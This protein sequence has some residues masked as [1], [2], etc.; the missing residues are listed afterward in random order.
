MFSILQIKNIEKCHLRV[1]T[2]S[3]HLFFC[4]KGS[5]MVGKCKLS[6]RIF[7]NDNEL[8]KKKKNKN[9]KKIH[10]YVR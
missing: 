2:I 8:G 10:S 1:V 3:Y 5:R 7:I 4:L 6:S 9:R